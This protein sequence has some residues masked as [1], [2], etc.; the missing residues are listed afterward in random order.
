[1]PSPNHALR[2]VGYGYEC[3]YTEHL[4]RKR[5]A[6]SPPIQTIE[7]S[8][9]ENRS[10]QKEVKQIDAPFL[11]SESNV[12][13]P[14]G[15]SLLQQALKTRFTSAHSSIAWPK[16]IGLLLSMPA[17]PRLQSFA[18]NPGNRP[19][20]NNLPQTSIRDIISLEE[21]KL[22]AE[23]FFR[24]VHPFFGMLSRELFE[25]RS[26]DFWFSE[27]CGADFEACVCTIVALGSYFSSV[28]SGSEA[29]V[30]EQGKVLLDLTI[31]CAPCL[32]SVKHVV[33]WVLRAIYL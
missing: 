16:T 18:W 25:K 17:P 9:S 29:R 2:A 19:E 30:V 11:S 10:T 32:L 5:P 3:V 20:S 27:Q 33:A 15:Q 1:M 12:Q 14:M 24:T 4:P 23:V 26:V 7:T 6:A 28:P 31:S 8:E 13:D 22:Y 21:M